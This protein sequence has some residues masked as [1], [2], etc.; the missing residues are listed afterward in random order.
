MMGV[1]ANGIAQ[2]SC[3]FLLGKSSD[4]NSEQENVFKD[5][6]WPV[7]QNAMD[8]YNGT[9]FAYGKKGTFSYEKF[10]MAF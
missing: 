7:I 8:G 5:T 1:R 10:R 2:N 9:I 3:G 6:V 4:W